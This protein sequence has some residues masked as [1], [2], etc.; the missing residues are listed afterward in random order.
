MSF[1]V[2]KDLTLNSLAITGSISLPIGVTL[3]ANGNEGNLFFN[4]LDQHIYYYNGFTW[5]QIIGNGDIPRVANTAFVDSKYGLPAADAELDNPSRPFASI[6]DAYIAVAP[7]TSSSNPYVVSISPGVFN[8]GPMFATG[9]VTTRGAGRDVTII[10]G[11]Y[12]ASGGT[13]VITD[14]TIHAVGSPAIISRGGG[15]LSGRRLTLTSSQ[16]TGDAT[17]G[18][19]VNPPS[20]TTCSNGGTVNIAESTISNTMQSWDP[21]TVC[22]VTNTDTGGITT[23]Q[24]STLQLDTSLSTIDGL[25]VAYH[26][27]YASNYSKVFSR[28]NNMSAKVARHIK[29]AYHL[30]QPPPAAPGVAAPVVGSAMIVGAHEVDVCDQMTPLLTDP[31]PQVSVVR[32]VGD[33]VDLSDNLNAYVNEIQWNMTALS[34]LITDAAAVIRAESGTC[35]TMGDKLSV[36]GV[37]NPPADIGALAISSSAQS[38]TVGLSPAF[39]SK[40]VVKSIGGVNGHHISGFHRNTIVSVTVDGTVFTYDITGSSSVYEFNGAGNSALVV[41]LPFINSPNS[42]RTNTS[43]SLRLTNNTPFNFTIAPR[44]GNLLSGSA[45]VLAHSVASLASSNQ[46]ILFPTWYRKF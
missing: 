40:N 18:V 46:S 20:A 8:E 1:G 19:T 2:Y 39:Q 3:P 42:F 37:L 17:I 15:T 21:T 38:I 9:G 23:V 32:H 43:A 7:F 30:S 44:G 16:A 28:Y 35:T 29:A 11:I 41:V 25:Q 22:S 34:T 24:Y 27:A 45:T 33:S 5:V 31:L 36:L 14:L 6:N 26:T 4:L 13:E 12:N 10:N